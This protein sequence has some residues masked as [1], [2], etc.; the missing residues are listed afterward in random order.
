MIETYL[1][2]GIFKRDAALYLVR[3]DHRCK[4]MAHGQRFAALGNCGTRQP[5]G[6]RED[7]AEVVG[8]MSPLGG[9]PGVV[10]VEPANHCANIEGGLNGIELELCAW[11]LRSVGYHGAGH[12]RTQK[13][14]A[15][16]VFERL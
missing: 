13:L 3:L 6:Y 1:V 7:C 10:E 14:G 16:W 11:D 5:V 12:D 4:H 9:Q 15:G 2:E 8:G